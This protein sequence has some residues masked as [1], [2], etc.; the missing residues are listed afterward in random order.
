MGAPA[1]SL[2]EDAAKQLKTD[3]GV[4]VSNQSR[5]G[6]LLLAE[7]RTL[8]M[9]AEGAS[10]T[11]V[12]E[13]LC[14]AI[15]AQ[16]PEIMST[17]MLMDP[18]GKRLWPIGGPRVPTAWL[19]AVT[20]LDIGPC[21]GSCSTA[22]FHKKLVIVS[23]IAS[24]PLWSGT[25]AADYRE[26]ALSHG[27]RAAWSRPLISKD[28]EVLGTFAMYFAEPRNPSSTDLEL[29]EGAANIAVIAIEGERS[30][31]ALKNAFE[32]IKQS[33][34]RLRKIIDAIPTFAWCGLPD[35]SKEFFNQQWHDYTGL[36][37]EEAHG[38]GWKVAI[39]PDDLEKLV[40]KWFK[41]VAW[42]DA[43]EVEA[44]M[45][46]FDGEYRWFLFRV[47]PLRDEHG[48]VVKWYGT[49]TDIE[50]RKRVEEKL[51]Q[52]EM[53]LRQIT[54]AIE[55]TIM[56]LEPDGTA[57]Y[58]NQSMLDFSGLTMEAVMAA[59]FRT[60]FFHPEDV[61]RLRDER[62][63]ALSKGVPFENEQRARRKDGQ[64]RWFLIHYK[65]LRN[66]QGQI[67]RWYAT[68][69]DI[70]DRKQDE[71]RMR[72]E[73][74]ALREEI[75]R[76]SMFEEIVGSSEPLH[77]VLRQV[78]RVAPMDSTVLILG[79]TGVGKELI[80]RAIHKRSNRATRAFIRVNC[81]AIPPSLIA[82]ELFGHEKG[83]FT[84]ATQRRLGRFESANGGTIFLDEIG[85][86]PAE[87]QIALLRVLQEREIE[88]VG[89]SQ[90]ISVDVRVVAATNSDLRAAVATGTFRED[91]FYRL[92]VFPIQVPSLRE[93]VDDIPL[94]VEYLIERYAKK[95]GKKFKTITKRTL[96]LFRAY[97]WPGNIRELQNV[98]ERAV[99]LSDGETFSV[100]QT[101]LKRESSQESRRP[102]MLDRGLSRDS[103]RERAL[104]EA[105]LAESAGRISGAAGAAS[106]L[107]IP[108]QTLE[109]KIRR[110]GIDKHRF[111]L[112]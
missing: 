72:S 7:R 78:A 10:L 110:L 69:T 2:E 85:D 70:E 11:D 87:T 50:D 41:F 89:S 79:E 36:S 35:G 28:D 82:S 47:E 54:D 59:D 94:L 42:G 111:Q 86:L 52:E 40:D 108:R 102:S 56:V 5:L 13:G 98:V 20:P 71:E 84:G 27:L 21:I 16:S 96:D 3:S 53:E 95:A 60:Q 93:R 37:P 8:E 90:P 4:S 31:T 45:R 24:D 6:S 97:D 106:K 64:Y 99:I 38:W 109:S 77:S 107:G 39:H 49:S 83:A 12:L 17:I 18:D 104:I 63:Q 73:N 80:A 26:I 74:L 101:W 43:G 32:E 103:E 88:R 91:L 51:R 9:I 62:Q 55:Q 67:I 81:A 29:I 22:A 46:R 92:N 75:D 14:A 105:A 25:P 58:A 68:G 48:N 65:P 112:S 1:L 15:D 19:Q 30:Q 44:R 66:E 33:E 34:A 57:I 23:D 100:D 61:E 76:A